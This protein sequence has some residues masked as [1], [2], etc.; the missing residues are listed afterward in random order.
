MATGLTPL[1]Y[2]FGPY[3]LDSTT[4]QLHL[5]G[6]VVSLQPRPIAVLRALMDAAGNLVTKEE[7]VQR[8]WDG[9]AI[10]DS[11]IT[12]CIAEIRQALRPGFRELDPVVT[13]WKQGYRFV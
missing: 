5:G 9:A 3:R 12:K 8:V 2:I 1:T 11:N 13:V 7:L 10:E 4:G 6:H